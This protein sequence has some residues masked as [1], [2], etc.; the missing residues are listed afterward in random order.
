MSM[1]EKFIVE[2]E[3]VVKI[4]FCGRRCGHEKEIEVGKNGNSLHTCK[5]IK[6]QKSVKICS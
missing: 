1:M 3:C 5:V 4:E 2:G 6:E